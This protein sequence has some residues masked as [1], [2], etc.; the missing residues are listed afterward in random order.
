MSSFEFPLNSKQVEA[1]LSGQ[2][3]DADASEPGEAIVFYRM[4]NGNPAQVRTGLFVGGAK[5][6]SLNLAFY[7][8]GQSPLEFLL[9][10]SLEGDYIGPGTYKG[11][12]GDVMVGCG[13]QSGDG[14]ARTWTASETTSTVFTT[15]PNSPL[16]GTC[17][18]KGLVPGPVLG[19]P[20]DPPPS[21]QPE[22]EIQFLYF[23]RPASPGNAGG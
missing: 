16:L 4:G 14:T 8:P 12:V 13:I 1:W 22:L 9:V 23:T 21:Q 2:Q 5:D 11:N 10:I 17:S 19:P 6:N 18:V 20:S 7:D 15:Y 3:S